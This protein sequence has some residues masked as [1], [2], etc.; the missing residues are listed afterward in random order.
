M[1]FRGEGTNLAGRQTRGRL[2][3]ALSSALEPVIPAAGSPAGS[4]LSEPM[5]SQPCRGR[6]ALSWEHATCRVV[7]RRSRNG[8]QSGLQRQLPAAK[9]RKERALC[10]RHPWAPPPSPCSELNVN[11]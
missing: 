11:K 8:D 10:L 9:R 2:Q 7:P 4:V 5:D 3:A 1:L 6:R